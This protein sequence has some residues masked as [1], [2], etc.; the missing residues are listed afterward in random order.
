[1][2]GCDKACIDDHRFGLRELERNCDAMVFFVMRCYFLFWFWGEFDLL[3]LLLLLLLFIYFLYL[4]FNLPF[5]FVDAWAKTD[6][7]LNFLW[8]CVN[9]CVI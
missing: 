8:Q 9:S 7:L 1:M 3:L 4:A 5:V 2:A 6:N